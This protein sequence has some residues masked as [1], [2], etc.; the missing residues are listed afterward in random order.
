MIFFQMPGHENEWSTYFKIFDVGLWI[1]MPLLFLTM[2]FFLK[3]MSEFNKRSFDLKFDFSEVF[4]VS[5]GLLT[6]QSKL[7]LLKVLFKHINVLSY[8]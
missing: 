8:R 5:V 7:S 3:V 1:L 2:G 6:G 4:L